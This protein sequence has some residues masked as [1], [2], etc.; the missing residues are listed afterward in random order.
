M[1]TH[2]LRIAN[3]LMHL[4]L[5][6]VLLGTLVGCASTPTAD[7]IAAGAIPEPKL[8]LATGDQLKFEFFGAPDLNTI[9]NIRRDGNVTSN[10]IGDVKA[11]GMTPEALQAKLHELYK[12]Q[13]QIQSVAVIVVSASPA[14]VT[15]AVLKP[16]RVEMERPLTALQAIMQAGGFDPYANAGKVVVIRHEGEKRKGYVLDFKKA[17]AGASGAEFFLRPYDIVYVPTRRF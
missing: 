10:L 9:Q 15:G 12:S 5:S 3:V 11:A 13:L 7:I 2:P 16:G 17:L 1:T 6:V 8:E 14:F 4:S